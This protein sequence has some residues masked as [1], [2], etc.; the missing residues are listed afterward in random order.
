LSTRAGADGDD[1]AFLRLFLGGV[2]DDDPALGRG[3]FFDALHE[4]AVAQGTKFHG[5]SPSERFQVRLSWTG[6]RCC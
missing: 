6:E 2:G 3:F 4:D 1:F 5:C